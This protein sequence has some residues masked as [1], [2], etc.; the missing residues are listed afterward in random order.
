M[1][2]VIQINADFHGE[3]LHTKIYTLSTELL[4]NSKFILFRCALDKLEQNKPESEDEIH[5]LVESAQTNDS[6]DQWNDNPVKYGFFLLS[7]ILSVQVL[8]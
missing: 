1:I 8:T 6:D 3:G 4:L 2:N 5:E 7:F